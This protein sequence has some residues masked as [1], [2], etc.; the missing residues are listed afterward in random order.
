M[1]ASCRL[2]VCARCEQIVHICSDCDRGNRYC[3]DLCTQAA[4]RQSLREAGRRYQK[5]P[6]GAACHARREKRRRTRRAEFC[7]NRDAS[8]FTS[9]A[10]PA[11]KA[12]ATATRPSA[13]DP[14]TA[15]I[16]AE[17]PGV[18]D[19]AVEPRRGLT[20]DPRFVAACVAWALREPPTRC[21]FCGCLC[22]PAPRHDFI[23]RRGPEPNEESQ[24]G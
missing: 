23:R 3:G 22:D 17:S 5:K 8:G 2:F 12:I 19:A 24:G 4:R 20:Q 13:P 14:A 16:P 10:P 1:G 21:N 15:P 11:T 6:A 18:A 7:A 9:P